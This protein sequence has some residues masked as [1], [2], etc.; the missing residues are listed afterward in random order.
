MGSIP[1]AKG[2]VFA[3]LVWWVEGTGLVSGGSDP[4]PH[5]RVWGIASFLLAGLGLGH[6]R[7]DPGRPE[8]DP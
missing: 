5:G 4:L 7:L 3:H 1:D 6:D 2:Q 8:R